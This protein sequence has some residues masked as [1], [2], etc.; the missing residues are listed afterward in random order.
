M[1]WILSAISA[2]LYRIG[3]MDK[4]LIPFANTKF[5]DF[6]VPLV[7][8]FALYQH[9]IK[10]YIIL[11]CCVLLFAALTTY[12]DSVF[13]YDNL[14]AHGFICGIALFPLTYNGIAWF[15]I[16]VYSLCLAIVMGG[17]NTLCTK[18][19][20]PFS[21]WIEELTRGAVIIIALIIVFI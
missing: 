21:D 12:W 20:I 5:R 17:L 4:K 14:Y 3:G 18:V 10:W 1:I 2:V 15:N 13:G 11:A 16:V 9:N 7:M 8:A 19:K 6:G